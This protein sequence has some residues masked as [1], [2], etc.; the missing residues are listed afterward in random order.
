LAGVL[1]ISRSNKPVIQTKP[2]IP[3]KLDALEEKLTF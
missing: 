3:T 1:P 2:V